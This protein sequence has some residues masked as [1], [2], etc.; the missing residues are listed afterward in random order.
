[1]ATDITALGNRALTILGEARITDILTDATTKGVLL[2]QNYEQC[3]DIVLYEH[4][5]NSAM[6]RASVA[7]SVTAPIF[8]FSYAYP[9]PV[10]CLR[11]WY[12]FEGEGYNWSSEDRSVLID[13]ASPLKFRYV[14]RITDP[15]RMEPLLF[16]AW[17]AYLAWTISFAITNDK[18]IQNRALQLYKDVLKQAK[19]ADGQEGGPEQLR[20]NSNDGWQNTIWPQGDIY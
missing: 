18:T 13:K 9:F 4:P 16:E 2:R 14:S 1:M 3:R 10:D 12:I 15:S 8:E 5:W 19:S 7:A 17:A 20:M 11:V 6:K